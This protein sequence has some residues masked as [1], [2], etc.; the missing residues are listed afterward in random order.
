MSPSV[1]GKVQAD[2]EFFHPSRFK[3]ILDSI[4]DGVFTVD[5]EFLITS[6]N[7]AAEIITGVKQ[8]EALG[9]P[10][11]EVLKAEI[12]E[13]ECALKETM[14]FARPVVNKP[15][16][17]LSAQ[18]MRVPISVSTAV[19]KNERGNIIGGVETFRDLS[20]EEE[21]RREAE[22]K[23]SFHEMLSKNSKMQGIFELL[24]QIAQSDCNV[25]L[26]GESG[27]GKELLAKALHNLSHRSTGPLVTL[28][29]GALPDSL[30]ES[31]LFGY[32]E[33]AFTGA[34]ADKPGR[35]SAAQGGTLFLDEIG[36]ISPAMQVKLL[37]V[38]QERTFEPLGSNDSLHTDARFVAATHKDLR[39][40]VREGHFREDLYYR[41]DVVQIALP[42]LKDRREDIPLLIQ[43]FINKLNRRYRRNIQTPDTEAMRCLM[44]YEWPGNIRELQNALEHAFV[45]CRRDIICLEDLPSGVRKGMTKGTRMGSA[46]LREME[47]SL[48]Q[49]ALKRHNGNHAA[50]ARDLGIHKTTLWRKLKRRQNQSGKV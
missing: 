32:K 44:T 14:R 15:V 21:L 47:L 9:K 43:H 28:N 48:V 16:Q 19:L 46:N 2:T 37:R 20:A 50:A 10:C 18:G 26:T 38:L 1:E 23:Y 25:L 17:I 8:R 29:C 7:R 27:T 5:K 49:E 30:L 11:W 34:N 42:P 40:E 3:I 45:L 24:P 41:L 31:E 13:G 12:C 39:N 22:H 33:G 35:L 4:N 36:D 6:F